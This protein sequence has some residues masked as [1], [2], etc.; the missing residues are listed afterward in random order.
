MSGSIQ[1]YDEYDRSTPYTIVCDA[2]LYHK[3][4][5]DV[6]WK[7]YE[8]ICWQVSAQFTVSTSWIFNKLCGALQRWKL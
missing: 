1:L 5:L 7:A 4:I 3:S 8:E 2:C 6:T